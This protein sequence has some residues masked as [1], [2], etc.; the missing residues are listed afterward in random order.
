MKPGSLLRVVM[1]RYSPHYRIHGFNRSKTMPV[2]I[3]D[4]MFVFLGYNDDEE[5]KNFMR[6]LSLDG[7]VIVLRTEYLRST[8]PDDTNIKCFLEAIE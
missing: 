5:E 6:C 8:P 4:G 1:P 2:A 7:D 3:D